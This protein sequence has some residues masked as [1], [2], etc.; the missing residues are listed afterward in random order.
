MN[1]QEVC[2][3]LNVALNRVAHEHQISPEIYTL[4]LTMFPTVI[5]PTL[6]ILD[7]GKVTKIQCQDSNQRYFYRVRESSNVVTQN[8]GL[9]NQRNQH[10]TDRD[11]GSSNELNQDVKGEMCFCYFY[12]KECMNENGGAIFCKHI[13]ACKLAEALDSVIIKEVEDKDFAPL[14]LGS[15]AYMNKYDDKKSV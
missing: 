2:S 4:L 11:Q 6:E 15:R 5:A 14:L 3:M 13:L 9:K 7:N 10:N 12:A 1:R 8:G